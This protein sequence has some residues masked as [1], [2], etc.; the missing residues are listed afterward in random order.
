MPTGTNI[1]TINGTTSNPNTIFTLPIPLANTSARGTSTSV[2]MNDLD[3][4]LRIL[5]N[6]ISADTSPKD[7]R[8]IVC[9]DRTPAQTAL[10]NASFW[11]TTNVNGGAIAS[12]VANNMTNNP[13]L[14]KITTLLDTTVYVLNNQALNICLSNIIIPTAVATTT[15]VA[16][17]NA[18]TI[19]F[20]TANA[21][22]VVIVADLGTGLGSSSLVCTCSTTLTWT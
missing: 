11:T 12:N 15:Y 7:V 1:I 2:T 20:I 10:T 13:L 17:S 14:T 5:Y 3:I 8:V 22:Y 21:L 6:G 16:G 18:G 4:I 19:G 9:I